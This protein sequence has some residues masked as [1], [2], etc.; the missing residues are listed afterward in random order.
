MNTKPLGAGAQKTTVDLRLVLAG[1][2]CLCV[3]TFTAWRM[4]AEAKATAEK[5]Q[6]E[7]RQVQHLVQQISS[8]STDGDQV[9]IVKFGH[10]SEVIANAKKLS[11]ITDQQNPLISDLGISPVPNSEFSIQPTEVKLRGLQMEQVIKFLLSVSQ[12]EHRMAIRSLSFTPTKTATAA[13]ELWDVELV[14]TTTAL[15]TK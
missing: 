14:L 13:R 11:G 6:A 2:L 15:S 8:A 10:S 3:A 4:T 1:L 9:A 5:S 12:G 7:L